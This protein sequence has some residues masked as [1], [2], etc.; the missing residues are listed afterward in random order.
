MLLAVNEIDIMLFSSKTPSNALQSAFVLHT[1]VYTCLA[2]Q[3]VLARVISH[4]VPFGALQ[5]Y[6][7]TDNIT[8]V[9][10]GEMYIQV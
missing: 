2:Q 4:S 3:Y 8:N 1:Q 5:C 7:R 9:S 6:L 10:G